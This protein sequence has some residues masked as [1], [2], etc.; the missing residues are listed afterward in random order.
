MCGYNE[1]D[2]LEICQLSDK[3]GADA[4]K[5]CLVGTGLNLVQPSRQPASLRRD[6]FYYSSTATEWGFW[7]CTVHI[8]NRF[9]MSQQLQF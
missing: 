6:W 1:E 9:L 7:A 5:L 3:A 2:W 4:F 8:D